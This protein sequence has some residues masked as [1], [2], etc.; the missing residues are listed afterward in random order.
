MSAEATMRTRLTEALGIRH[1][2]ATQS[3]EVERGQV[4]ARTDRRNPFV[5]PTWTM[6]R[7]STPSVRPT[8]AWNCRRCTS[9][10]S[11][12]DRRPAIDANGLRIGPIE[13]IDGTPVVDIKP[14]VEEAKDF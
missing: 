4:H 9:T 13:A 3:P 1:P 8:P 11:I 6:R 14:V 2:I 5:G 12:S 10:A 7:S